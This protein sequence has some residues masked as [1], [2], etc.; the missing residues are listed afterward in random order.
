[1]VGLAVF[2]LVDQPHFDSPMAKLTTNGEQ[3]SFDAPLASYARERRLDA[4][5]RHCLLRRRDRSRSQYVTAR[6]GNKASQIT[7]RDFAAL[8]KQTSE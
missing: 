4:R 5:I 8:R 2:G 6:F 3:K 1:M 7:A